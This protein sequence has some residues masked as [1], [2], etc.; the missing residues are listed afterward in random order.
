MINR[1]S[2]AEAYTEVVDVIAYDKPKLEVEGPQT[3][4]V[5][6]EGT[7][8]TRLTVKDEQISDENAV[9]EWST[10]G[11]KAWD[12]QGPTL[13]LSSD[14]D[15]RI[16]L[17]AR[18]R[19]GDAPANDEYA[20]RVAKTAVEFR[21]VKPPRPYVSG[22]S[23]IETGKSYTFKATTSLPYKGMDVV[24]KGFFILPNGQRVDGDTAVFTPN[25]ED[26]TKER[27]ETTYTAWIEGFRELGAEATHSMYSRVWEYVWP[28]FGMQVRR[29]AN[30]A[31]ATIIVT[32]RP[33]GFSGKL[34]EAVYEWTLPE[35]AAIEDQKQPAARVFTMGSA[36]KYLVKLKVRDA[37]GNET[38]LEEPVTLGEAERYVIDLQ[39]SGSNA[40]DREPL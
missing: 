19:S 18:V 6:S 28:R 25:A 32:A 26:L 22:P 30:V 9:V 3:L 13:T 1:N 17:W 8:S 39:Y 5:G 16:K 37:R 20:Y 12:K 24:V 14:K 29:T 38:E 33:I 7:F 10:D 36:G 27:V 2:S 40:N 34:D 11:G 4:F 35:G 21:V 23:V 31:P 15:T